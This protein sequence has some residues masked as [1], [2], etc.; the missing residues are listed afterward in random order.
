MTTER[1]KAII[2]LTATLIIGV[3][4]GMLMP[5]FVNKLIDRDHPGRGGRNHDAEHKKEWF[6][7]TIYRIVKPDS[8]QAK[9]IKPITEW[10]S[11]RIDFIEQSSNQHLAAILDSM[12]IQLKPLITEEQFKR[13]SEFDNKARSHWSNKRER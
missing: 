4:L 7:G 11:G 5:G 13:F 2:T 1:R 6:V 9:Q 3:L 8:A 12:K 10:A